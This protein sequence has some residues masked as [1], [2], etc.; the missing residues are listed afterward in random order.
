LKKVLVAMSGGVDSSMAAVLLKEAG[1]EVIGVT[2]RLWG[3]GAVANARRVCRILNVP[4]YYI[5]LE[6]DFQRHV[7]D[8]FCHEYSQGRTP[9]P[10]IICNRDIKFGFLLNLPQAF[11]AHYLATGHYVRVERR[12]EKYYLLKGADP[13]RDQSYFLY[14]L[15]QR[16][17]Q[18][19]LFPIGGYGK[20]EVRRMAAK[21]GLL[22]SQVVESREL[23]FVADGDYR[24][25]LAQRL[26]PQPGDIVDVAGKVL[27]RHEGLAFYTIGQRQRLGLYARERLYV[28][29]MD[30][31]HNRLIVG[32]GKELL[33]D[34]LSAT[35]VNFVSGEELQE[36]T[37]VTAKIRYQSPQVEATLYPHGSGIRV[38]F[39]KPQRAIAPG[40][41]VVFYQDEVIL[42]GGVI[43]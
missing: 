23:C 42:G 26:P 18:H 19:L 33:R 5:N 9:N 29:G 35:E 43:A 11:G 12:G 24:C 37:S 36:P 17:L 15:G 8:Y 38:Q 13:R 6:R 41:A 28:V 31:V 4:F 1:Y 21:R 22:S 2:L 40:Q 20:S 3:D 14:T 16:E 10:C 32:A 34:S 25:F 7:V 39:S 30:P 27:G